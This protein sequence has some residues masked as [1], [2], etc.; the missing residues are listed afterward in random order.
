MAGNDRIGDIRQFSIDDMQIGPAHAA[1]A[2]LD[3]HIAGS[4]DRIFPRFKPERRAGRCQDH[5]VHLS[6]VILTQACAA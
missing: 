5:G 1:G 3:A 6:S 4:G 2:D